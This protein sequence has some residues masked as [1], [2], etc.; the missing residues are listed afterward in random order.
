MRA[1]QADKT[2]TA[3]EGNTGCGEGDG[4]R[5]MEHRKPAGVDAKCD[6]SMIAERLH[7]GGARRREQKAKSDDE[8]EG[9]D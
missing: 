4:K 9:E 6:R 3:G 1:D 2:D 5:D 8:D 7:V